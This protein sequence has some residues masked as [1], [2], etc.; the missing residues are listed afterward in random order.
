MKFRQ[1]Y[2]QFFAKIRIFSRK[3]YLRLRNRDISWKRALL[4]SVLFAITAVMSALILLVVLVYAGVFGKLPTTNDLESIRNP[5]ASEVY[6]ADSI[7]MGRYY[8]QNRLDLREG[9]MTPVIVNALLDTEDAR[10]YK[11]G[12]IDIRSLFR[13]V[14]KTILL[15][16]EGSGGGSTITQQLAKNIY[17]RRDF[18][19]LS[20]PV[21]KIREM[22]IAIRLEHIYTK[23]EILRLYLNT[24][25]FGEDTYGIKTAAKLYFD[26]QPRELNLEEAA[27]LVGMLKATGYYNPRK[28]PERSKQRRN[29]VLGQLAH[30]DYLSE[31]TVDSLQSLPIDLHY[32][33]LPYYAGIAPYFREYLRNDMEEWCSSHNKANGE[34]YNLYTDGLKIY[35]TIDSRMQKHAV[36]AVKAQMKRLQDIFDREWEKQNLWKTLGKGETDYILTRSG[37]K[38]NDTTATP[39]TVFS[40]DGDKEKRMTREDSVKYFMHFL[41]AG[42]LV[43][44]VSTAGLKAWVGGIDFKYFKFDHVLSKRQPGSAFKPLVY[45]AALQDGIKPCDFY[46][47]D[48][49][50]YE[51]YENWSPGNAE[52]TYGGMYSVKGALTH[53]I[54]TVTAALIMKTGT[55]PV[56]DLAKKA[57]ISSELPDV[58]SIALGTASVSLFDMVQVYRSFA[59]GGITRKPVYLT[60]ITDGRGNTLYERTEEMAATRVCTREDADILTAMLENVVNHGTGAAIRST[61][62]LPGEI[63]GKTGTSQNHA[64][65][66]FMGYTP[67]LVAGAWVGGELPAIRF[68]SFRYGQGSAAAL[69]IFAGFL[70]RLYAD[71][72]FEKMKYASFNIDDDVRKMLDCEDYREKEPLQKRILDKIRT[73][74]LFRWKRHNDKSP[75]RPDNN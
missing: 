14:I 68:R 72:A 7:L 17:P 6:S 74:K 71:T 37:V 63:A 28:Y 53:S 18:G 26:K 52:N 13:V 66:W 47:N 22:L 16:H 10:F 65:G 33:A 1:V 69:P 3:L 70:K 36:D 56:L 31:K 5:L 43:M 29:I 67:E 62:D 38:E 73:F 23:D 64:D 48:S 41:Q 44:D 9:E 39:I 59:A 2:Q 45:L 11:H 60:G 30:Y 40:Y 61:Y 46:P 75:D 55:E 50:V 19:F 15:G 35:T 42:F 32:S 20:L 12:G 49:V 34:A 25:P 27:M 58:P 8:I 4:K 57:G 51:D 24:V 21:N 54:N